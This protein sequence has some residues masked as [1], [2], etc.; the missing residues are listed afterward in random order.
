MSDPRLPTDHTRWLYY[1]SFLERIENLDKANAVKEKR[2][3]LMTELE[4]GRVSIH[5]L[6][7][8]P[9]SYIQEMPIT[10]LIRRVPGVG[11]QIR[12]EALEVC[13]IHPERKVR[14]LSDRQRRDLKTFLTY[15]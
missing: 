3:A 4:Q 6:L 14:L 2:A 8:S 7:D 11:R 5:D 1:Q 10:Q 9:P 15:F 12:A 13:R